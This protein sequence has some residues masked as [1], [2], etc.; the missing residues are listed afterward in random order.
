MDDSPA[1]T[2]E[3]C[4]TIGYNPGVA[5]APDGIAADNCRLLS[6][7]GAIAEPFTVAVVA[8]EKYP[9][10]KPT[11]ALAEFCDT[12]SGETAISAGPTANTLNGTTAD[13]FTGIVWLCI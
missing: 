9:P 4:T 2:P 3:F 1:A 7:T 6:N 10:V 8:L 12:L 11:L 5:S 13:T